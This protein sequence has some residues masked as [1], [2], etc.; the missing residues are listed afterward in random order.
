VLDDQVANGISLLSQGVANA[1]LKPRVPAATTPPTPAQTFFVELILRQ[2]GKLVDR[3]VYW[4]STQPDVVDWAKTVG[5]PQATMTQFASLNALQ[6]LPPA[7]VTASARTHREEGE[8]GEDSLT[9]TVTVTNTSSTP[10]VGFFMRAD[11]R[12]GNPDG[13]TRS[14]DNQVL[15]ITWSDNDITL[16]PGESQT[17]TATYR[18]SQLH[19]ARPVVTVYGWNVPRF[20]VAG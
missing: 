20:V 10:T 14:G 18:S 3:N 7:R 1:V 17:V 12:R 16:W 9:T 5:N 11:V 8:D 13:S 6:S 15:P 2:Q 4:R 19:G